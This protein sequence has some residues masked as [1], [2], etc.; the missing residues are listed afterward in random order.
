MENGLGVNADATITWG[1]WFWIARNGS[2]SW[3]LSPLRLA[4]IR[5]TTL[6]EGGSGDCPL[7]KNAAVRVERMANASRR[8]VEGAKAR[9]RT[10]DEATAFM[11]V[12]SPVV[13]S[14]AGPHLHPRRV[15]LQVSR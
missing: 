10:R 5:L 3:L 4:G 12:V 1:F 7:A 11:R 8:S 9:K 2:L 14:P 15:R 6:M 13:V